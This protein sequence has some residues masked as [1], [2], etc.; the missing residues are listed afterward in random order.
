MTPRRILLTGASGFV[1]GHLVPMLRA[2]FPRAEL[3]LCGLAELDITDADAVA[4]MVRRRAP[5]ACVHLA[6][7]TAVPAARRD[8]GHAWRVNLHGTL[9]LAEAI[10]AHAPEC[11]L[12]FVSSAEIYGGSFRTGAPLD[13]SATPAPMNTYAATKAAADLALGAMAADG[14]RVVR[15]R[16]FNHTGPGQTADF[17]VPA[18]ARQIARIA[19]GRQEPLMQVGA[20]EP[21]RD[22]LD[23]RDVCAAY[24]AC[25]ARAETLA[26]GSIFNIAS[27]TPRR[28]G[29]IL[30]DML[31]LAGVT[32][33]VQSSASLLR[34]SDIATAS[35]NADAA[36]AA[37]DWS[38]AIAWQRTL[39]DVLDDWKAR[40]AAEG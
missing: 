25:L 8:P 9:A 14:L 19:A 15:L 40:V 20:L 4:D 21:L 23:V 12:L 28:I 26:P 13:E 38:A 32:A 29:D 36:R 3:S 18:F 16:P 6:A 5:D 24:L 35:G 1:A 22:F 7:V 30:A 10:V 34:P 27:G 33:S 31:E 17:V 39:R 37:L 2:R 11:A